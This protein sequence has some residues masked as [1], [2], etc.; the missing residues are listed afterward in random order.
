[1]LLFTYL[2]H[3]YFSAFNH[4]FFICFFICLE[5]IKVLFYKEKN[6]IEAETLPKLTEKVVVDRTNETFIYSVQACHVQGF[7]I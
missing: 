2:T 6:K 1:M 3:N 7:D 5:P 4:L